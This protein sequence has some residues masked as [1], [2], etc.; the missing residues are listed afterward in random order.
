[1]KNFVLFLIQNIGSA[2][3][4][5]KLKKQG[6]LIYLKTVQGF[7]KGISGALLFFIFL[8]L[9]IFGFVGAAA[10]GFFLWSADLETKLWTF[11]GVCSALFVIPGLL[12]VFFLSE[13]F[14]FKASGAE[15]MLQD[16]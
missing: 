11:F 2:Y 1:M 10:C 7:R 8:Q 15:K 14:W 13:R 4:G 6:I 5:R 16:L 9:M 3:L 12:L